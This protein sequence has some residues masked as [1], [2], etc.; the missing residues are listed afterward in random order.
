MMN[1]LNIAMWLFGMIVAAICSVGAYAS[2]FSDARAEKRRDRV[3]G[4]AQAPRI[5]RDLRRHPLRGPA[6]E[7]R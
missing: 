3:G 2:F 5:G 6:D 1:P 7:P 4:L